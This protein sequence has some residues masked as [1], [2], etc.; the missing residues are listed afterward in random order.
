M[1]SAY[2]RTVPEISR[3]RQERTKVVRAGN[4]VLRQSSAG[5]RR[6]RVP[7]HG[8]DKRFG[9]TMRAPS[10]KAGGRKP[11]KVSAS[12]RTSW[13][14]ARKGGREI[15]P[16]RG[17]H[18]GP[19]A[20]RIEASSMSNMLASRER[21]RRNPLWE[22]WSQGSSMGSHR[23]RAALA[24]SRFE[25]CTM[26]SG[27]VPGGV[28]MCWPA[29]LSLAVCLGRQKNKPSLKAISASTAWASARRSR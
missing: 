17:R 24:R 22:G 4:F 29:S 25:V 19:M 13:E 1:S 18:C 7:P 2:A 9:C 5:S 26:E 16:R 8:R 20:A 28:W 11:L 15:A 10:F 6:R 3:R 12:I 27:R 14:N 21:P 23:R